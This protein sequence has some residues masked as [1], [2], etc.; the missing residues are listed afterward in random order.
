MTSSLTDPLTIT[1]PFNAKT[2]PST[3]PLMRASPLRMTTFSTVS[4][5]PTTTRPVTTTW[6]SSRSPG[7]VPA[8]AATAGPATN[9]AGAA[10]STLR[11]NGIPTRRRI[12][13]V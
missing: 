7:W 8:G 13:P 11:T 12:T 5:S 6:L 2:D 3:L 1:S 9:S 10:T 4:C